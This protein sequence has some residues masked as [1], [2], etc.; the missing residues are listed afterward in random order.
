MLSHCYVEHSVNCFDVDLLINVIGYY[1]A[2]ELLRG[3]VFDKSVDVYSFGMILYQVQ[4]LWT[5]LCLYI[6]EYF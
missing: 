4:R 6:L 3:E 5:C 2:P 1:M